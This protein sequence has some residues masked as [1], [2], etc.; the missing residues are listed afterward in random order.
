M[1]MIAKEWIEGTSLIPARHESG[2]WIFKESTNIGTTEAD[3][4]KGE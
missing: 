3:S 2:V 4:G 1:S